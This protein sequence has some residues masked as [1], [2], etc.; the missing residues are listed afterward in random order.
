MKRLSELA[1][2]KISGNLN[3]I[4]KR[5]YEDLIS[6]LRDLLPEDD[7]AIEEAGFMSINEILGETQ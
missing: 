3:E 2:K 7:I 1:R 4:D 5:E 6:I